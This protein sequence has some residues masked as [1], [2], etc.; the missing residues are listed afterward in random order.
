MAHDRLRRQVLTHQLEPPNN[1]GPGREWPICCKGAEFDVR[2]R[3]GQEP[4]RSH[5]ALRCQRENRRLTPSAG[6]STNCHDTVVN[7]AVRLNATTIR[8]ADDQLCPSRA[9]AKKMGRCHR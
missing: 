7:K 3:C 1:S 2:S 5:V 8:A 9:T 6:R 4:S